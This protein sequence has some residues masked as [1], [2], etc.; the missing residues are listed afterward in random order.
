M[1]NAAQIGKQATLFPEAE[2]WITYEQPLS[3][4]VRSLL[5]LEY[6]FQ[7]MLSSIEG[8]NEWEARNAIAA[9]LDVTDLLTRSDIKGEL[10]KE[11]DRQQGKLH[12]LKMNPRVD[13]TALNDS[14]EVLST[15]LAVLRD[16]ASQPGQLIRKDELISSIRQRLAIPGGTCNFDLPGFHWWLGKPAEERREAVR[17]WYGDLAIIHQ[18]VS[19]ALKNIRQSATPSLQVAEK[20]T[21]QRTLDPS[22][23]AHLVRV[24]LPETSPYYPEISGGKHRFAVRFLTQQSTDARATPVLEEISFELELCGI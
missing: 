9:M 5:R 2:A 6:L 3:E 15:L 16:N 7:V 19:I 12:T 18:C 21:Y 1:T 17:T 4:R 20:G 14:L 23:P 8:E 24:K 22:N 13:A 11:L 10:I